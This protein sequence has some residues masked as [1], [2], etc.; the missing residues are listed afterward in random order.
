MTIVS[1]GSSL[2]AVIHPIMLNNTLNNPKIGFAVATRA[3]AGL[4]SGLLLVACLVMRTRVEPPK[5]H[6]ALWHAAKVFARD[7]P[8]IWASLG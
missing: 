8:Y 7:G 4:I 5:S 2:G 3:N 6:V 1:S